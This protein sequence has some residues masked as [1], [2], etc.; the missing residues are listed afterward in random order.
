MFRYR[1]GEPRAS[2]LEQVTL[3]FGIKLFSREHRNKILIAELRIPSTEAKVQCRLGFD[4]RAYQLPSS[5]C[6]FRAEA[7]RADAPGTPA[8]DAFSLPAA[9][10]YAIETDHTGTLSVRQVRGLLIKSAAPVP[11]SSLYHCVRV[12]SAACVRVRA[13]RRVKLAGYLRT[14]WLVFNY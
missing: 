4:G 2:L 14:S 7:Y 8:S 13:W 11:R 5:C 6:A 3:L 12:T 10:G 9:L 1:P